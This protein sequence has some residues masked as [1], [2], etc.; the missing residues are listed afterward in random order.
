MPVIYA[1]GE[2]EVRPLDVDAIVYTTPQKVADLLGIAPGEPIVLAAN[3]GSGQA[4]VEISG[5]DYRE[6]GFAAGDS[7]LLY[8]DNSPLGETLVI[9]SI[10]QS[11]GNVTLTMTTNLTN[12]LT[13]A[14]NAIA[15]NQLSFTNNKSRGVSRSIVE[16]R[17]KEVQDR[18]DNLTHNAWRPYLVAAEYINFDTYKPYRRRY[19]TDYV[20]TTPLLFRNIQQMLRIELWQGDDYRELAAAEA[21]IEIVDH[22]ELNVGVKSF[23]ITAGGVGYAPGDTITMSGGT[24]SLVLTVDTVG[25]LTE[26]TA[27]TITTAGAGY[28]NGDS[29]TQSSTN[30]GGLAFTCDVFVESVFLCPGMD[31]I[32]TLSIGTTTGTWNN[33]F[34]NLTTAQQLADLINKDSRVGKVAIPFAPAFTLEDASATGGS[35]TANLN[36]EFLASANSDYGSGKLKLTSTRQTGGG[37]TSTIAVTDLTNIALSQTTPSTTTSTSVVTTTVNVADTD[38]FA[39]KG[40][41]MVGTGTSVDVLRY[42]GLTATSFT[43]CINVFGTPLTTLAVA[44]TT[45]TQHSLAT[46]LGF[47]SGTSGDK[48]RLKDWWLDA[49][50]GIVYFNNSYPFFEWNAVKVSYIYG[51]RYVEKA[52]E[53]ATTKMVAADLLMSDDRSV[54]I[55]EGTQNVDLS[56]KIQLWRQEADKILMRYKEVVVFD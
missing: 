17:I 25:G 47:I 19:Y 52:I 32:S 11:G 30:G 14:A 9:S 3:A 23:T 21:R 7:V 43:G 42:T 29:L 39:P 12:A 40:L 44:G 28:A 31:G 13:T 53:E 15:Q 51:E 49:E 22:S 27:A 5:T 41:L 48:A 45:V 8:D 36:H 18:I 10:S 2:I 38:G 56:S 55:P 16:T 6:H 37:Q 1:P 54:L 35:V 50:M 20:G 46:D 26:V 33:S 24:T 34:D 4:I